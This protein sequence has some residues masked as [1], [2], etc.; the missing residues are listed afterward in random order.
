M[1]VIVHERAD[2]SQIRYLAM[3]FG[4]DTIRIFRTRTD[5]TLASEPVMTL[6]VLALH[7][8]YCTLTDREWS[9]AMTLTWRGCSPHTYRWT[10][11]V[12]DIRAPGRSLF[13]RSSI[14]GTEVTLP[15]DGWRD[16]KDPA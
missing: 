9:R 12:A 5:G 3:D 8:P 1:S 2:T 15:A 11:L 10:D 4:D 14:E 13:G 6:P 16:M 7:S